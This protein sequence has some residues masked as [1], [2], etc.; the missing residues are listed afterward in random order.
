[1]ARK[2][3][4]RSQTGIYHVVL[5]GIN[6]QQ[7][8][9]H[10]DDYRKFILILHDMVSTKDKFKQPSPPRCALF[11]FCLLPNHVHLLIKEEG[12]ILAEVIKKITSRYAMYYNSKYAHD[13]H[14][15]QDRFKSEPVND[16]AFFLILFRYIHQDPVT[17]K[18]CNHIKNYG[19][20]SWREYINAP[21]RVSSICS[22]HIVLNR[23]PLKYL[24]EQVNTPLPKTIQILEFDRYRGSIPD[25]EVIEFLQSTYHIKHPKNIQQY[26]KQRR[27]EILQA[28][29]DFGA[30]KRQ[31][32]RLTSI[33]EYLISHVGKK[34]NRSDALTDSLRL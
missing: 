4:G 26:P 3:R 6:R 29:I 18:V 10:G 28:V 20:S 19:W 30:S 16:E 22:V 2:A 17:S 7:I 8:F 31:L 14:L 32:S 12:E 27:N 25:K 1:M 9:K 24:I 23:F 13:G 33:S 34:K 15:F 21:K 5:C 11:S